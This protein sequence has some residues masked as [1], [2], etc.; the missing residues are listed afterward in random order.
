[1]I[2]AVSPFP[3]LLRDFIALDEDGG[4]L[5]VTISGLP[6]GYYEV[7]TFHFD[8]SVFASDN[9]F[10]LEITDDN[11]TSI[12]STLSMPDLSGPITGVL[13]YVESNG[14][15]DVIIRVREQNENDRCRLNGIA[16]TPAAVSV[17]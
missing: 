12:G 7:T 10:R 8:R 3:H 15:D 11:G 2:W 4:S 13:S 14:S 17:G 5:D 1:M 9:D 16:I 6:A